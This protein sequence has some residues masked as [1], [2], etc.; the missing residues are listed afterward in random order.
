MPVAGAVR[1]V[2]C[3]PIVKATR[4][5]SCRNADLKDALVEEFR[6]TDLGQR[7]VRGLG[8]MRLIGISSTIERERMPRFS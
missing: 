7:E 3:L 2:S 8:E 1:T 4:I 5:Q 6:L